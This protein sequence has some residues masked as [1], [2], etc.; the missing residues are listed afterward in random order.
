MN[1]R[2]CTNSDI[3]E[4]NS[5]VSESPN[6]SLMHRPIVGFGQCGSDC[7]EFLRTRGVA[8]RHETE[9][10][11]IIDQEN[12]RI[13]IFDVH[14][15]YIYSFGQQELIRP[16]Y[17]IIHENFLFVT[18][19]GWLG[20]SLF[21]FDTTSLRM[22]KRIGKNGFDPI[23]DYNL[24]RQPFIGPKNA[25]Y[26][27]D[28][29]N[30]RICVFTMNLRRTQV[31]QIENEIYPLDVAFHKGIMYVLSNSAPQCVFQCDVYGNIISSF[32][33]RGEFDE[34]THV[35]HPSSF[36]IDCKSNIVI[37]DLTDHCVKVFDP[38]GRNILR[39]IGGQG[40]EFGHLYYPKSILLTK[41][42]NL[43]ITS[44]N[45]LYAI[46]IF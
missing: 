14:G 18:D 39:R 25:L 26:I 44:M 41:N 8:Y 28:N 30:N 7:G 11:F 3:G 46:Q 35:K 24:L 34:R 23:L 33:T 9:E 22:L 42:G 15:R 20:Y 10:I 45:E 40:N 6:Y 32:I 31:I 21:K 13:Q 2:E 17:L 29:N 43:I 5:E 4:P 37:S 36:T 12:S 1:S 16:S 19:W 38:Q 27:P